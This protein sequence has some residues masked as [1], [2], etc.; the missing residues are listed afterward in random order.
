MRAR[1]ALALLAAALLSCQG[2]MLGGGAT[3]R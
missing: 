2:S 1:F 3:G